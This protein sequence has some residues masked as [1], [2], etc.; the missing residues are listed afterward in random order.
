MKLQSLILVLLVLFAPKPSAHPASQQSEQTPAESLGQ[1]ATPVL[2][3]TSHFERD[4]SLVGGFSKTSG[5]AV[6]AN[7][8]PL[9]G[10]LYTRS[11]TQARA[12]H[13]VLRM[14]ADALWTSLTPSDSQPLAHLRSGGKV[15]AT[16]VRFG[17]SG[18]YNF[19]DLWLMCMDDGPRVSWLAQNSENAQVLGSFPLGVSLHSASLHPWTT[20]VRGE[21]GHWT[22]HENG[23][24]SS[25]VFLF[26]WV[27]LGYNW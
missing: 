5:N 18:C 24:K 6:A 9:A 21:I 25:A 7:T 17:F 8:L 1:Q 12:G 14:L 26:G 16:H 22:S 10:F 27:G 2:K 3:T 4:V 11:F 20:H 15:T 19:D 23:Q 13:F